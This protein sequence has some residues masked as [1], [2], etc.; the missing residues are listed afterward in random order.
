MWTL[1]NA[2]CSYFYSLIILFSSFIFLSLYYFSLL[3]LFSSLLRVI[4]LKSWQI[5]FIQFPIVRVYQFFTLIFCLVFFFFLF[6]VIFILFWICS[7]IR[8]AFLLSSLVFRYFS[9]YKFQ[10]FFCIYFE[11]ELKFFY[12][13]I[14]YIRD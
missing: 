2:Y 8:N 12:K 4:F 9:I 10:E 13:I 3:S 6:L 11:E 14:N 5:T 1:T 7:K